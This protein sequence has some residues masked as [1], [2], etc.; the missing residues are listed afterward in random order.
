[1]LFTGAT[2]NAPRARENDI[3]TSIVR[4]NKKNPTLVDRLFAPELLV[5]PTKD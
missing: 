5:R 1:M 4:L 2:E 3:A